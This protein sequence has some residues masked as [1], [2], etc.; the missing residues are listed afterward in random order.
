MPRRNYHGLMQVRVYGPLRGVVG[1]KD[2]TIEF[3]GGTV[4]AAIDRFLEEYPRAERFVREEDGSLPKSVQIR[5]E[6]SVV[7]L[8]DRCPAT[9]ELTIHPAIQGG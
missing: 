6:G 9:A 7:S 4:D 1:Q 3:D 8:G 2:I 5:I